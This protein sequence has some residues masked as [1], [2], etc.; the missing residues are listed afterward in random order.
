MRPPDVRRRLP[1]RRASMSGS[2]PDTAGAQHCNHGV[3]AESSAM[4]TA[5]FAEPYRPADARS[6]R[7]RGHVRGLAGL[8]ARAR[9]PRGHA[10]RPVRAR[11][12]AG[13]VGRRDA[14]ASA[15]RT[16]PTR[17]TPR[18]R[19]ARARCGV[20]SRQ[21]PARTCSSS[22]AWRGSRTARTA[23]RRRPSARCG[24]GHPGRA[25][26]TPRAAV[27]ELPR[28]RSRVHAARAR[29]GRA[30]GAAR[31]AGARG[32]GGRA[33]RAR[34]SARARSRTA[35]RR[36]STTARGSR[37]TRSIWACGG[38][39]APLF[40]DARDAQGHPPGAAVPRRRPGVASARACRRGS[41]TTT[42]CTAPPTSTR[43]A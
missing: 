29:G 23:G 27:P 11:R 22:A 17:T 24:A 31:R 13:D 32:A 43:S 19:A 36:C 25:P 28:R 5:S 26:S 34:S 4:R 6:D 15:A 8:A 2:S 20:S 18:W 39:L 21:S 41:T 3:R 16:A 42:R 7:R 14:A 12:P 40:P 9:R 10:R 38:W 35:P 33:R 1:R 30:A 37:A